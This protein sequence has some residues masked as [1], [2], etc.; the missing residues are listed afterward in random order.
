MAVRRGVA[1]GRAAG[2]PVADRAEPALQ[3][4]HLR[5]GV[6]RDPGAVRGAAA[7]AG[8]GSTRRP[9]SRS[10]CRAAAARPARARGT[11]RWRWCS[12]PTSSCPARPA[13]GSRFKRE[14]LDVKIHGALDPR[15]A[16]VD[17]G[18]GDR[19]DS[20]TSR[21]WAWRCG[22]CSRWDSATCG[23]ASRPR[24]FPAARRSGSRSR[25][26]WRRR[27]RRRARKL[28]ILDEPTT[29]LHLDDVRVLISVLDR[30]V[31]AGHT[32]LVIE[33]HMDV[34][35]RADWVIDMG[36]EAG[37]R[38]RA[39]GG[40]GDAG[41]GRRGGGIAHGAISQG[42]AGRAGLCGNRVNGER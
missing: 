40:A 20:G 27:A 29:G 32:V 8:S 18:G 42:G 37:E 25:G 28:Y 19:R 30:L 6:R 13:A 35:K 7:V 36:P 12:W 2:G 11:C 17:G 31:D 3:S 14:V 15:R 33:H 9:P 39:G 23:W 26:S 5:Q 41:G 4:G 34:I 16:A 10:T 22:T 38:R 24:R 21:S 1:A